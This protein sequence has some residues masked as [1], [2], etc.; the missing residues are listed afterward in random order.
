[1]QFQGTRLFT[2]QD[3]KDPPP[4]APAKPITY[5]VGGHLID[6]NGGE[7]VAKPVIELE[8]G[9]IRNV[10]AG[11]AVKIP[12]GAQV[13][14]CS[15]YTLMPGMMDLHVH[16]MMYNCLTFA[17]YRVAKFEVAP[18]LQQMYA[19]FHAQ[20]CLDMGFTTLRDLGL[21]YP[22][23]LLTQHTCSV[24]D[25]IEA[26]IF[27]GPRVMAG[28]WASIT[29]S[30]LDLVMPRSMPRSGSETADGPWE[31]RKLTRQNLRIGCDVIKTSLS[32]GGGTDS[33]APDVRNLTQEELNA[34]V[35]EAH[36]FHKTVAA[37]CFTASGHLMAVEAG[38]DTLEH[39]VFQTEESIEAIKKAGI[40]VVPTLS[41]RTDH[42][43]YCRK[44]TGAPPFVLDKMKALQPFCYETFQKMY[45]A[46]VPIAMGTD[47][48]YDP[49]MGEG[50]KEL[51]LYVDLG[52]T[53]MHAI[54]T[55]TKHAAAAIKRQDDLGTIERGKIA[56]IIAVDGDPVRNIAVLQEKQRIKMVMRSGAVLVD[57]RPGKNKSA[58]S[59]E[60]G[61]WKKL[62]R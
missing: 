5:L 17:N 60:D 51:Q 32:G 59:V 43:I 23:G 10:S 20:M 13:V 62:A 19:L 35:D 52:M 21:N 12:D 22:G 30:H 11:E 46:G 53:P 37:H 47:V 50:A 24:R 33:E 27:P 39:M 28:G 14:D 18:Q 61:A 45:K 38:V 31:L 3:Q 40:W 26:G 16:L 48:G 8:G 6:G 1:M 41:H 44:V 4:Q 36:A 34:I 2:S 58:V 49:E 42:A 15:G 29:G 25:A 56:D 54:Q 9:R 7:P 55:A 57:R